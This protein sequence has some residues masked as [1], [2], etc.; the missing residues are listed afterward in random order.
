MHKQN[1]TWNALNKK[2]SLLFKSEAMELE[3]VY[4]WFVNLVAKFQ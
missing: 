4:G 2:V 3:L 1:I